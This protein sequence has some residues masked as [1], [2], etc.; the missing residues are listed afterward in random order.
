MG[1]YVPGR[2]TEQALQPPSLTQPFHTPQ[3]GPSAHLSNVYP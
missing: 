1:E 2:G 3:P